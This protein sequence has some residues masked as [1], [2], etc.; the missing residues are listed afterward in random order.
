[1]RVLFV[2]HTLPPP[3][4]PSD[5]IGGM[6][7]GAL[8]LYRTLQQRTDVDLDPLVLHT[9]SEWEEVR[10]V[11][12]IARLLATLPARVRRHQSDV[13]FFTSPVTALVLPLLQARLGG[14]PVASITHGLD[15][16]LPV[17]PYQWWVRR[18]LAR[19]DA[20]FPISRATAEEC[21]VR[22]TPPEKV[23][24]IPFGVDPNRFAG[25]P[26]SG[27]ARSALVDRL[28]LSPDAFLLVSLGRQVKRK[29]TEWFVRHVLS[30]LPERVHYVV[31]GDGPEMDAIREAAQEVPGR[32]HLLGRTSESEMMQA[33]TGSD[34]F[35]M[36]NV[37]V[38]GDMEG[39]GLVM[40]EAGLCGLPSIASNMEG[41]ADVVVDG[42]SG[43]LVEPLNADGFVEAISRYLDDPTRLRALSEQT[44]QRV[45]DT[46]SWPA[47]VDRYV[48]RLRTLTQD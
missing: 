39:Q 22:G 10:T 12:F 28:G 38:E 21:L 20:V 30:R 35:V 29:G 47:I 43:H 25:A 1:M 26:S 41:I 3:G 5:N 15:V 24:V 7:R 9:T 42:E 46:F 44:V 23:H 2:T 36:P 13:V 14:V 16:T 19:L 18:T 48:D 37:P 33:L 32:V 27:A 6:Q 31:A 45:R 34:L 11:G 8:E 4:R 17:A 40:L